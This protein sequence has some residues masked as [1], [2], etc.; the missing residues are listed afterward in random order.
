MVSRLVSRTGSAG[1]TSIR[2]PAPKAVG[3]C[4]M[5]SRQRRRRDRDACS[6]P[7]V[8]PLL[9]P[10]ENS[11][12]RGTAGEHFSVPHNLKPRCSQE[13]NAWRA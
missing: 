13:E 12:A 9:A 1:P 11:G 6:L 3:T 8:R 4:A 2:G 5:R 7:P 10:Q